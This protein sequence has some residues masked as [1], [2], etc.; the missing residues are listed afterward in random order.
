MDCPICLEK[1]NDKPIIKLT[2]GHELHYKCFLSYII[3][4]NKTIFINCPLCRELNY[5]NPK[6]SN[7]CENLKLFYKNE[8]CTHKTKNGKRCKNKC[9]FMNNGSCYIHR[10][11]KLSKEK[12]ELIYE[13]INFLMESSNTHKTKLFMIDIA[14]KIC[15]KFP[16]IQTVPDIQH[17]FFR[18]YHY[19]KQEKIVVFKTMYNYYDLDE[20]PEDWIDKCIKDNVYF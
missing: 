4:S 5:N 16:S 13:F 19:N 18:F 12:Y 20:P 14:K 10:K 8:R 3:K 9:S 15:I 6:L 11:N 7:D 17:Y 2:C 1:F